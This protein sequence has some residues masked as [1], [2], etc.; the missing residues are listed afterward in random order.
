MPVPGRREVSSADMSVGTLSHMTTTP[1]LP[2][3]AL[4]RVSGLAIGH[5]RDNRWLMLLQFLVAWLLMIL[6]SL[7]GGR[8]IDAPA[9]H[10]L[11]PSTSQC[12]CCAPAEA[13]QRNSL[14]ELAVR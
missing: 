8:S 13:V 6:I 9:L 2:P 7:G 1:S 14:R 4:R 10:L 3:I 12:G 11:R 5:G